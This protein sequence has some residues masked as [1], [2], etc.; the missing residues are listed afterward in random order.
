VTAN[1]VLRRIS[2]LGVSSIISG[3]LVGGVVGR[4]V[5]RVSAIAA[6]P[7]MTGQVTENGN[8]IGQFTVAGTIALL[9]FVGGLG[10]TVASIV[11]AGSDPWL[12]WMG[13][14][15][16]LGFGVLALAMTGGGDPFDSSDFFRLDPPLLN[17][18]MF[19]GLHLLF[20]LVVFACYRLLDNRIPPP[21]EEI[22]I[23]YVLV[24]TMGLL[25]L[26]LLTALFSVPS[27]CECQPD[28]LPLIA[29]LL[30]I[31]ATAV[32]HITRFISSSPEWL[33][34]L[35]T[36]VGYTSLVAFVVIG[37]SGSFA[38]ISRILAQ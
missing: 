2:L 16:G 38:Q 9:I 24:T 33:P 36:I 34:R 21:S 31:G 25:P 22:Q 20:G 37:L 11:V 12:T 29:I 13:P 18:A 3:V 1:H 32:R 26:L 35:A 6:G 23:G 7:A 14:T 4:V 10:G 8:T 15:Q 19:V 27:F 5:M 30:M 28:F 17:V